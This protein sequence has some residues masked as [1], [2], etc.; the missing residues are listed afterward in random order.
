M[1]DNTKGDKGNGD[2]GSRVAFDYIKSSHFRVLRA[3]GAIGGITPSGSIHFALYSERQAIPRRLV[4][5]LEPNGSL[6]PPIAD[7]TVSRDAVVREMEV[8]VFLSISVARSLHQWLG[9]QIEEWEQVR[10]RTSEG[11]LE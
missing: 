7:E 10:G 6:G 8:D 11:V 4:H 5:Q 2:A 3:D 9:K 1:A